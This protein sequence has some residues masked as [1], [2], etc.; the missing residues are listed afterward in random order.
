MKKILLSYILIFIISAMSMQVSAQADTIINL[1][2]QFIS[3]PYV[4]DG[5]VYRALVLKG[6]I[7]EFK[8]TFYGGATYRVVACSGTSENNLIF[9]MYDIKRNELF[10]SNT[11]NN[12]QYWNFKFHSTID[13]I[14]EAELAP[15]APSS[16]FALLLI[17]FEQ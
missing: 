5:Q 10:S 3:P 11:F 9:R 6:E 7:A 8:A 4:S 17:G 2:N 1:C 16:G 13:C 15:N 12:T 14:I